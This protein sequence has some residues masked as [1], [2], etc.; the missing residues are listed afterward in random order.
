MEP[1]SL[2]VGA[3]S[4][5]CLFS[6]CLECFGYFQ[7][8]KSLSIDLEDLLLKLDCQQER[9][10]TWGEIVGIS[11]LI[12]EERDP[13][14]DSPKNELIKRCLDSITTL[15]SNTEKLRKEYG[16]ESV[17]TPAPP[18]N[19][20]EYITSSRMTRFRKSYQRLAPPP[21]KQKQS[22]L[23]LKTK[24]AVYSKAKFET[25]INHIKENVTNLHD[26]LPVPARTQEKMIYKDIA[27]LSLAGLRQVQKACEQE[28]QTWSDVA[29]AIM[30]ASEIGT[31]DHRTIGEWLQDTSNKGNEVSETAVSA[32]TPTNSSVIRNGILKYLW[33][34][35]RFSLKTIQVLP[36]LYHIT[37]N[38]TSY[39][40]HT[41]L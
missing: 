38:F 23:L 7:A 15:L 13:E 12:P 37:P 4:L 19:C 1:V 17:N 31:I 32:N 41:V 28:Y 16:V 21:N 11:K 2:S 35:A 29:S 22:S 8:A 27:S 9:L 34:D 25:L 40:P 18:S 39:L 14:L 6:T 30:T 5:A 33:R 3:I 26:I 24:W 20:L 10:L 36:S